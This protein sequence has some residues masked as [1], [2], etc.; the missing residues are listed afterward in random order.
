MDEKNVNI[1]KVRFDFVSTV[2][3]LMNNKKDVV[4]F[5]T[6]IRKTWHILKSQVLKIEFQN[7]WNETNRILTK[8][9]IKQIV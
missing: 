1:L 7:R 5:E 3:S 9:V 4:H 6:S 8:E 2:S